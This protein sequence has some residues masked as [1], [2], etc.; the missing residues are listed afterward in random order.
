[1][2]AELFGV[3]MWTTLALVV[4][5]LV[6]LPVDDE[7]LHHRQFELVVV[8]NDDMVMAPYRLWNEP[9]DAKRDWDDRWPA[10]RP[11]RDLRPVLWLGQPRCLWTGIGD[12]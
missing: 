10:L 12:L 8:T 1:M 3:S 4:A 2:A 11:G 9:N 7:L 5:L 6:S